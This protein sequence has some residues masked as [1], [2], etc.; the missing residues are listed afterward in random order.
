MYIMNFLTKRMASVLLGLLVVLTVSAGASFSSDNDSLVIPKEDLRKNGFVQLAG[1]LTLQNPYGYSFKDV[2]PNGYHFGMDAA[3]GRWF[4]QDIGLRAKVNWG[5]SI[6]FLENKKLNWLAPFHRPGVNMDRGGYLSVV[7]DI[8]LNLH[9]LFV[10]YRSERV[11]N[12]TGFFRAGGVYNYG[13]EK[14]A[15]L[16]GFGIG[17]T[18]RLNNHWNLYIEAACNAVSSGFSMD[19]STLTGTGSGSNRYFDLDFGVTYNIVG[20]GF[21][22]A[23]AAMRKGGRFWKNWYV[24]FGTN[25]TLYNLCQKDFRQC[26]T[27]GRTMGLNASVGKWFTPVIGLRTRLNLENFLIANKKLEWLPYDAEFHENNYDGGGCVLGTGE[28]LVSAKHLFMD[29]RKG[30]KWNLYGLGRLGLG[31]NRS[32]DSYSPIVGIGAG[33][34]YRFNKIWSAFAE[35]VYQGITSEYFVG[36]SWSGAKG[37]RFN[38]IWDFSAGIQLDLSAFD[39]K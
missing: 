7:G 9:S 33:G 26:M 14:G 32:I 17:S 27:K 1:D 2:I 23:D 10:G 11:W 36:I 30:E 5:N 15:P 18:F 31:S 38:A 22:D 13:T 21:G 16:I 3:V 12:M 37:T 28:V 35:T 20:T 34:T 24:Q 25:M 39:F 6:P 8:M 29:Y 4:S 19:P